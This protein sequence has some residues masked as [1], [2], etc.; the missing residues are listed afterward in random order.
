MP[1][2][3]TSKAWLMEHVND[4]FVQRAKAEGYRSRAAYKLMEI[5][6]KDRLIKKGMVV[7]ELGAAPGSWSQVIKTR[8]GENGRVIALDLLEIVPMA[9]VEFIQADFTDEATLLDLE[10]R[11]NGAPVGLVLSDMA[12]NMSGIASSDQARSVYL[13][14]LA[15]EFSQ[16]NLA[17][18]GD[19]LVKVFQG[20]GF[21]EF[22]DAMRGVF[23]SVLVRKPKSSRGRSPEVYLLGRGKK[24]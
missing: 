12:P 13:A 4:P 20:S 5:D 2:T 23:Q 22:R 19:L 1:R 16:R 24:D 14:E 6:D 21:M 15:L 7:V 8:V 11:L 10:Q 17:A 18:G 3:K 9:G